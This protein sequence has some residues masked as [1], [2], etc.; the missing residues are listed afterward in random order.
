MQLMLYGRCCCVLRT[1]AFFCARLKL[2]D[3]RR[4]SE[5][6]MHLGQV[7]KDERATCDAENTEPRNAGRICLNSYT[8]R[9]ES[10]SKI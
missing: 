8:R 2:A 7:S 5:D 4:T 9:I 6:G 3:G 1:S 10:E